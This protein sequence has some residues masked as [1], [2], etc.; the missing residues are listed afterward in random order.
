[1][2]T[3][4]Y[5]KMVNL[6]IQVT[7]GRL[8]NWTKIE[9]GYKA[10]I[11]NCSV[12]I[13]SIYDP[14]VNISE[15]RLQLYNADDLNF[16][17]INCDESNEEYSLFDTLYNS[18]RDSYYHIKESEKDIMDSLNEMVKKYELEKDFT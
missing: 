3:F 5:N 11:G 18:I 13:F 1:M 12:S 10:T 15:Y 7:D 2:K 4:D 16:D 9:D 17:G 14:S 8:L 6:L